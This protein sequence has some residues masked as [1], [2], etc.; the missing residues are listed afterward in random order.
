[1]NNYRL[2]FIAEYIISI[3]Y[4]L[5]FYKILHFRYKTYCGEIDL[6]AK[7]GD[8]LVFIEVKARKHGLCE[9]IVSINQQ[10]RIKHT[11]ELFLSK[12]NQYIKHNIRFD[13][14]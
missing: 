6:I 4:F 8:L 2:G 10:Q 12:N 13:S 11:A 14:K 5:K 3:I 9:D 1:M 7:R